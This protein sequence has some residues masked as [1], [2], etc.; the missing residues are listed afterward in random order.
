MDQQILSKLQLHFVQ[1]TFVQLNLDVILFYSG[2]SNFHIP[3]Y[4]SMY[5]CLKINTRIHTESDK[6]LLCLFYHF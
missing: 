6:E 2:H 4:A 5:H 3:Q 1:Q